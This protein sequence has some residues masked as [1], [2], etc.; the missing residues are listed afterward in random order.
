MSGWIGIYLKILVKKKR[1]ELIKGL[2]RNWN[3]KDECLF[4]A[5]VVNNY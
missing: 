2:P 4:I 3:H 1:G 5:L